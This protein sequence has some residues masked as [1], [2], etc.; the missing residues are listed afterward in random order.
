MNAYVINHFGNN[1]KYLEYE[2]YF[3]LNLRKFTNY[4]IIYL[5]SK[6]DTPTSFIDILKKLNINLKFVNY[7]D[8]HITININSK[9]IS[10]YK[11]FN[12]LR[13]CNFI[14]AYLLTN[15]HKIC[16]VESDMYILKSIDDIFDLNTPSV[17]YAMNKGSLMKD[18]TNYKLNLNL[19]DMIDNCSKGTPINGGLMLIEPSKEN[20]KLCINKINEIIKNNCAFPN[21]TL[22][23]IGNKTCYNLPIKYNFLHYYLNNYNKFIDIR[24]IHYNNTIYKPLDIIKDNYIDKLENNQKK[25]II[26]KYY[27]NIYIPYRNKINNIIKKL[28]IPKDVM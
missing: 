5:Y 20:F 8:N 19:K 12:T 21:E 7:D 23:L 3:L 18:N 22:F 13:T 16:I 17:L 11:H 27:Q 24:L 9:F 25:L 10:K 26:K 1:Y 14:F 2:M 4:D 28:I 6:Y 15:Y